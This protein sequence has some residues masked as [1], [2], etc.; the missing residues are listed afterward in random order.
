MAS[1]EAVQA[2]VTGQPRTLSSHV[3][4]LGAPLIGER[5]EAEL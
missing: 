5:S 4:A 2:A 3:P 1:E